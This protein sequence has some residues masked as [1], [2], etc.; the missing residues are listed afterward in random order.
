VCPSVPILSF[1]LSSVHDFPFSLALLPFHNVHIILFPALIRLRSPA[2]FHLEVYFFLGKP[3]DFFHL[4][5]THRAF[6]RL[7]EPMAQEGP[8]TLPTYYGERTTA[9]TV[10]KRPSDEETLLTPPKDMSREKGPPPPSMSAYDDER[11]GPPNRERARWSMD[12]ARRDEYWK[13]YWERRRVDRE[14]DWYPEYR[15]P[16]RYLEY[17]DERPPPRGLS[18][19]GS[20]RESRAPPTHRPR[21][22][23]DG[24]IQPKRPI[25]TEDEEYEEDVYAE[26][27]R[28]NMRRRG[29]APPPPPP[30]H[31]P[32]IDSGDGGRLPFTAW[33]NGTIKNRKRTRQQ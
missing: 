5:A 18:Y 28:S 20:K 17:D 25:E 26:E 6:W 4:F 29:A 11:D 16:Q 2:P 23:Y 7:L 1:F 15:G 21:R 8:S 10:V 32:S 19:R 30:K 24:D 27:P 9:G 14:R 13:G 22:S 31:R 33:M 3:E 12:D